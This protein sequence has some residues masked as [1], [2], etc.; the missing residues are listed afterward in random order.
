M[1]NKAG[2]NA[3]TTASSSATIISQFI[4]EAEGLI[5]SET[6]YD[7][8]TNHSSLSSFAKHV[9]GLACANFAAMGVINY[10]PDAW[11]LAVAET[12]L[13]VLW[14]GYLAA[15]RPLSDKANKQVFIK[16]P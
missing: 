3:N 2:A 16:K 11:Q 14:N 9:V 15:M 4:N 12:K 1:I 5:C 10:D 13:D 6:T 8:V 7:W